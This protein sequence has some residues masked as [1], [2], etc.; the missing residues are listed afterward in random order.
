MKKTQFFILLAALLI[1]IASNVDAKIIYVDDDGLCAGNTPCYLHPQ[2]AINAADPGDRIQVYPG[3]YGSR[4]LECAWTDNCS[5]SDNYSPA[6]IVYKDDLVIE[7]VDADPSTTIIESTHECVSNPLAVEASTDGG[8]LPIFVTAPNA[9]SII[10]NQVTISGFTIRRPFSYVAGDHDTVL[11]GGLYV[12]YG[13]HGEPVGFSGNTIQNCVLGGGPHQNRNG[14]VVWHSTDNFIVSNTI[15]DPQ[16]SAIRVYDGWSDDELA[17]YPSSTGNNII[18]N[19]IVDDPS[20]WGL[21]QAIFVGAWNIIEPSD[22]WADNSGTTVHGND[23]GRMGLFTAFSYG[24]KDFSQ[25]RN[26]GWYWAYNA[27]DHVF[28]DNSGEDSPPDIEKLVIAGG[29]E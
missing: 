3:L 18:G 2:D 4:Y 14:V 13:L 5:Y 29:S 20:T 17:L 11:I 25:N 19:I 7:A 6:L 22:T 27:I 26:V 12:G 21:G 9:V 24:L 16:W 15:I 8:V 10:A 28:Q 1:A 23:C